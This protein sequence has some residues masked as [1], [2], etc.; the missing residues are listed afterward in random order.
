MNHIKLGKGHDELEK[1]LYFKSAY[2]S[3]LD[4]WKNQMTDIY[5]IPNTFKFNG[6]T[7]DIESYNNKIKEDYF[8]CTS[9]KDYPEMMVS[10]NGSF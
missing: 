9:P 5:H 6:E 10:I 4:I 2:E 3:F 1:Y 8:N 7:Y